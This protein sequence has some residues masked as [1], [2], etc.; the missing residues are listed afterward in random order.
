MVGMKKV[1]T[2]LLVAVFAVMV[3]E[4]VS[5]RKMLQGLES[6]ID[7]DTLQD[8]AQ[9]VVDDFGSNAPLDWFPTFGGN[10]PFFGD[11]FS[12]MPSNLFAYFTSMG[13]GNALEYGRTA[14][15]GK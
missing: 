15:T 10:I 7:F 13:A 9:G 12:G 1:A 14:L 11:I 3:T 4:A 5:A 8:G 6:Y 2:L